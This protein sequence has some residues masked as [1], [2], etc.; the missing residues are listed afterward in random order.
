MA[1]AACAKA[2]P[3]PAASTSTASGASLSGA[4]SFAPMVAAKLTGAKRAAEMQLDRLKD[5]QKRSRETFDVEQQA[6]W[7]V[8]TLDLEMA[9]A[10]LKQHHQT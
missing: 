3:E 8:A 10:A 5:E 7:A 1:A 4:S 2:V 6:A 9:E